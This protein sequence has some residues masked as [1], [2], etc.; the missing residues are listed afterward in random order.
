[1]WVDRIM[2]VSNRI[3]HIQPTLV[4]R[5]NVYTI[6]YQYGNKANALKVLLG[7]VADDSIDFGISELNTMHAMME[8]MELEAKKTVDGEV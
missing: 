7:W 6:R 2:V 3:P 8:K 4:A 1:M 5:K